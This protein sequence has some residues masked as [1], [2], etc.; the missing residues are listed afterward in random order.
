VCVCV[1]VC[2]CVDYMYKIHHLV[3]ALLVIISISPSVIA[4]LKDVLQTPVITYINGTQVTETSRLATFTCSNTETVLS[5]QV[6]NTWVVTQCNPPTVTIETTAMGYSPRDPTIINWRSCESEDPSDNSANSTIPSSFL[7]ADSTVLSRRRL[8]GQTRDNNIRRRLLTSHSYESRR[9]R[10]RMG[11]KSNVIPVK[12]PSHFRK[13]M[14][15]EKRN[16]IPRHQIQQW[17][18]DIAKH[19]RHDTATWI[20]NILTAEER[21]AN[22]MGPSRHLNSFWD[23][24]VSAFT[25]SEP[26]CFGIGIASWCS[27]NS[28]SSQNDML[29]IAV[30]QA[31]IATAQATKYFLSNISQVVSDQNV[32]NTGFQSQLNAFTQQFAINN[33]FQNNTLATLNLLETQLVQGQTATNQAFANV[34]A[35]LTSGLSQAG[36]YTDQRVGALQN[37]ML[38]NFQQLIININALTATMTDNDGLINRRL[39]DL[40]TTLLETQFTIYYSAAG[41]NRNMVRANNIQYFNAKSKLAARG[42]HYLVRDGDPGTD[43]IPADQQSAVDLKKYIESDQWNFMRNVRIDA[44]TT[45]TEVHQITVT[46]Y[47]NIVALSELVPDQVTYQQLMTIAGPTGCYAN[48]TAEGADPVF[49]CQAWWEVSH[50]KCTAKSNYNGEGHTFSWTGDVTTKASRVPYTLTSEYCDANTQPVSDQYDGLAMDSIATFAPWIGSVA[51]NSDIVGDFQ[52]VHS[53]TGINIFAPTFDNA[54]CQFD[55]MAQFVSDPRT[56]LPVTLPIV[57]FANYK[58]VYPLLRTERTQSELI[59]YGI[60]SGGLTSSYVPF[61]QTSDTGRNVACYQSAVTSVTADTNIIYRTSP[62][63]PVPSITT[64]TYDSQPDCTTI[65]GICTCND[66]NIIS[67]VT[68]ASDI[69]VDTTASGPVFGYEDV[70]V[71]EWIPT[72]QGGN[73]YV[74]DV[75]KESTCI[76]PDLTTCIGT[77]NYWLWQFKNGYSVATSS[78]N[79]PPGSLSDLEALHPGQIVD[80]TATTS[81]GYWERPISNGVCIAIAGMQKNTPCSIRDNYQVHPNTNMRQGFLTLIPNQWEYTVSMNIGEGEIVQYRSV[82]CPTAAVNNDDVLGKYLTITNPTAAQLYFVITKAVNDPST[83]ASIGNNDPAEK[84]I[85]PGQTYNIAIPVNCGNITI[86]IQSIDQSTGA[87]AQCGLPIRTDNV[88]ST[89]SS[90]YPSILSANSTELFV[91]NS[92]VASTAATTLQLLGFQIMATFQQLKLFNSNITYDEV[93]AAYYSNS[94]FAAYVAALADAAKGVNVINPTFIDQFNNYTATANELIARSTQQ[95]IVID[96][97]NVQIAISLVV[98]NNS[99]NALNDNIVVFKTALTVEQNALQAEINY[100]Q[101]QQSCPFFWCEVINFLKV[102]LNVV[103]LFALL[104][105]GYLLFMNCRKSS[106]VA[107]VRGKASPKKKKQKTSNKKKKQQMSSD[108]EHYPIAI[109]QS[110]D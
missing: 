5:L 37:A 57:T 48:A 23:S 77:G 97:I 46:L 19:P 69:T 107:S 105:G 35:N 28:D 12:E 43:P 80:M 81:N 49:A 51:C 27:S 108:D 50:K 72:S 4:I 44:E 2:V 25:G 60:P 94:T 102:L 66:C 58:F 29:R 21:A 103:I 30:D 47:N 11:S 68:T 67:S 8:L 86:I 56:V 38:N 98:L 17:L 13:F 101:Q 93:V 39:M 14:E 62:G 31:Q 54:T 84:G 24:V 53:R 74:V 52:V 9:D 40:A 7:D 65:P 83:C 88:I 18:E 75:P 106:A 92:V 63:N 79:P 110:N 22:Q 15:Y 95:Q 99:I 71:G 87:L 109:H 55:Y 10:T 64:T 20:P 61:V 45:I 34:Y 76:S 73:S 85:G 89:Q 59:Q 1:C 70:I 78:T 82:G 16:K 41:I 26:D 90:I 33:A 91:Q 36:S 3:I 42:R 104:Y 96:A 32:V 6:G 100:L